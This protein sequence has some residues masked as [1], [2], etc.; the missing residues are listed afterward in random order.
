M[1]ISI[2]PIQPVFAGE[3]S[4][5]DLTRPL[6]RQEVTDIEAGMDR[7]AVLVFRDQ[8]IDDDQ[9][10]AFTLNFG[11]LENAQGGNI[12]KDD[13][14]RL[15]SGMIDVSNRPGATAYGAFE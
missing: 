13:E 10:M 4:G 7:Y 3:V 8:Q 6:S 1:T 11:K 2:R 14:Y 15:K 5:V 9:Q 12:T